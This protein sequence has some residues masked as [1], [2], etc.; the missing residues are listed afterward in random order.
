MKKLV[1]ILCLFVCLT[2][3]QLLSQN[4]TKEKIY[5]AMID[6]TDGKTIKHVFLLEIQDSSLTI[7]PKKQL[8]SESIET[9]ELAVSRIQR[10]RFRRKGAV[11]R[12]MGLGALLG[13][14]IGALVG[15]SD[16]DDYGQFIN[17]T[18]KEKALGAGILM[19]FPGLIFGI[20]VGADG[21]K[22]DIDGRQDNFEKN[23]EELQKFIQPLI[24]A[25]SPN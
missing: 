14:G 23:K 1:I 10:I 5:Q 4:G 20:L 11:A 2:S 13:F 17:F 7:V 18:A 8:L 9:S 12:G 15:Y 6:L 22:F 24:I 21:E 3:P 19:V 16:G 25:N